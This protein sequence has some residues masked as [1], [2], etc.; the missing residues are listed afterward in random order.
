MMMLT[1]SF[2]TYCR[3]ILFYPFLFFY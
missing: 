2:I 1:I 3:R